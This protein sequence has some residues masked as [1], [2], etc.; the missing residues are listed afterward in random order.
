MLSEN[1]G[2]RLSPQ[3]KVLLKLLA[4]QEE[5]TPADILRRLIRLEAHARGL[6]APG[7]SRDQ[8][9]VDTDHE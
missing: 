8:E 3:E 9:G 2:F 6:W 1:F 4:E 5:R 7:G